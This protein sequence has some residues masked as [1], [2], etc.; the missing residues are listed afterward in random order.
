MPQLDIQVFEAGDEVGGRMRS[1]H[2]GSVAAEA[3]ASVIH[4]KNQ[5]MVQFAKEL[6]L[7]QVAALYEKNTLGVFDGQSMRVALGSWGLLND[8]KLL[9][10]YGTSLMTMQSF[11]ADTL[12]K[13]V[14]VYELQEQGRSFVSPEEMLEELGL[15]NLTRVSIRDHMLSNLRL[16]PA[17]VEELVTAVMRVNYGQSADINALTGAISLCGSGIELWGVEGG[18]ARVC[19][20]LLR[21]S[22]A[23]VHTRARVSTVRLV[24]AGEARGHP[25]RAG[26]AGRMRLEVRSTGAVMQCDAVVLAAPMELNGIEL[27]GFVRPLYDTQRRQYWTT[28]VTFLKGQPRPEYF[29]Y[30]AHT[31]PEELPSMVLTMERPGLPFNSLGLL[32]HDPQDGKPVFKVFSREEL[33][34]AQLDKMFKWHESVR[35][36]QW[37]AYPRQDV[38][39]LMSSFELFP[40]VYHLNIAESIGSAMEVSAIAARNVALLLRQ[41]TS[42]PA[43]SV[44]VSALE[45]VLD[46]AEKEEL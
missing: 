27:D 3:G 44:A 21:R 29:G 10:R 31:D 16:S 30:P 13:F 34:D 7:P 9:W 43:A 24:R 32:R 42:D 17:L 38:D 35:R 12:N 39:P 19:Q 5:Y 2:V 28:H 40:G 36:L 8:A 46:W 15:A 11:V 18:N 6:G 22:G 23:T 4:R 25:S 14:R 37:K 45:M 33:T 20:G 26:P 41:L 1:V